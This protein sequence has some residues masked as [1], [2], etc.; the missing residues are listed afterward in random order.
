[1]ARRSWYVPTGYGALRRVM[2]W[3]SGRDPVRSVAVCC[4]M[5]RRSG[6]GAFWSGR[7][8]FGQAQAWR[9]RLDTAVCV[10]FRWVKVC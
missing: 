5:F 6:H 9:S 10:G 3:R 2:F 4:G 8:R 1:M 7:L